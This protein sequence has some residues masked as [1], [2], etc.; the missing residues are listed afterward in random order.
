M[1]L[2]IAIELPTGLKQELE[3]LRTAIPGARW[4]PT[5]QLHLTLAFLG[6]VAE[7]TAGRLIAHLAKI[8]AASFTLTF[9]GV[10]CFP[11]RQRPRVVWIGVKP[12]PNLLKLAAA[13]RQSVLAIGIFLEERPFSPHLTLARLKLPAA[14]ELRA[15]IDRQSKVTLKPFSVQEFTLFQSKLTQQG[16]VH[17]PIRDFP[18]PGSKCPAP[19][20]NRLS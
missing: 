12:E 5:E 14:A 15:F 9:S 18:L 3:R 6:E 16:A 17:S 11:D 4:V 20:N 8:R 7:E 19:T 2:F 10:G 13:V 1:R